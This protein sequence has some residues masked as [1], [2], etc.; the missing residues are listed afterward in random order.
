MPYDT[1]TSGSIYPEWFI[2]QLLN[3][4]VD[5]P[6]RASL[7][8]PEPSCYYDGETWQTGSTDPECGEE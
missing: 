2:R 1:T 6:S 8:A 4:S 3:K 7:G 5:L